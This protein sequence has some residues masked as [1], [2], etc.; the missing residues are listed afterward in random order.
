M[1]ELPPSMTPPYTSMVLLLR[2]VWGTD[3]ILKDSEGSAS[4]KK[5][6]LAVVTL[7]EFSGHMLE[8]VLDTNRRG[9]QHAEFAELNH[10]DGVCKTRKSVSQLVTDKTQKGQHT[11]PA[12]GETVRNGQASSSSTNDNVIILGLDVSRPLINMGVRNRLR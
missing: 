10:Q 1:P 3:G 2:W 4:P 12:L 5:P 11:L 7:V 8:C 9:K 6:K